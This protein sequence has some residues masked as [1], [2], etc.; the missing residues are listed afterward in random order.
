MNVP[1]YPAVYL[2]SILPSEFEYAERRLPAFDG[3]V[4]AIH[5][6]RIGDTEDDVRASARF[7][8]WVSA[9]RAFSRSLLAFS[10]PG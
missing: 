6:T 5:L 10:A 4:T 3:L 1:R 8:V 9:Q 2:A 7:G